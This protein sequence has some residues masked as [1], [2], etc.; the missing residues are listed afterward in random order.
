MTK[1]EKEEENEGFGED[2]FE[3]EDEGFGEDDF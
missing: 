1:E 3:S 2:D